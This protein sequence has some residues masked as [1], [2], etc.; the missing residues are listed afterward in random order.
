LLPIVYVVASFLLV[1]SA[2]RIVGDLVAPV[3]LT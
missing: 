1:M 3:R 2:V